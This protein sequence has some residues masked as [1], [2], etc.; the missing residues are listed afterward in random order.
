MKIDD[1]TV[2]AAQGGDLSALTRIIERYR[3]MVLTRC[4]TLLKDQDGAEDAAQETWLKVVRH[5]AGFRHGSEL[6]SWI[7]RIAINECLMQLR[8]DRIHT[9]ESLEAPVSSVEGE[10]EFTVGSSIE[11]HDRNLE[12]MPEIIDLKHAIRSIPD[13]LRIPM[14]LFES[15]YSHKETALLLGISENAIKSRVRRGRV[16]AKKAMAAG[17]GR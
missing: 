5:I 4:L 10:E 1:E 16:A 13:G 17:A 15:G 8:K 7:F 11:A 6:S 9:A 2:L 12:L 14:F 3:H